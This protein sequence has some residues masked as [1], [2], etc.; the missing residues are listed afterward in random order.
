[1]ATFK[2]RYS[3]GGK[4]SRSRS[5]SK[6]KRQGNSETKR[7]QR[8]SGASNT[9]TYT[10]AQQRAQ[11]FFPPQ[12]VKEAEQINQDGGDQNKIMNFVK[13][14]KVQFISALAVLLILAGA[15]Y[16]KKQVMKLWSDLISGA[17]Q[18]PAIVTQIYNAVFITED[19]HTKYVSE[20][21]TWP[22]SPDEPLC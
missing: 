17:A 4:A 12:A 10:P 14:Y 2:R 7:H 22:G 15:Y 1:M 16:K 18:I 13:K 19:V 3:V 20:N 5:N 8:S 9:L 21:L 6:S 11:S